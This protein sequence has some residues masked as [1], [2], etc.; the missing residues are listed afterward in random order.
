MPEMRKRI[1]PQRHQSAIGDVRIAA[2]GGSVPFRTQ[3]SMLAIIA[4]QKNRT[5]SGD[6]GC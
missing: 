2:R 6:C 5:G 3:A 4:R 1:L